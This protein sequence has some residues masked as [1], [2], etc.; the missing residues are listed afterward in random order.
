[1]KILKLLLSALMVFSICGCTKDK[2]SS[3]DASKVTLTVTIVDATTETQLFSGEISAE[4]IDLT[5]EDLLSANAEKLQ[6][7]SED[8]AYGMQIN[9][10]MGV[11]T[12]DWSAGPWWMYSSENNASCAEAGFCTGASELK[13]ADGDEFTFTFSTGY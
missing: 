7:V 5:L 1:M 9:G 13:V 2:D 10:L 6:L 3:S 8:S 4:G 12:E 11:Q